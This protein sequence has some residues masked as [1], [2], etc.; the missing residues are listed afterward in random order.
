MLHILHLCLMHA[1]LMC[2]ISHFTYNFTDCKYFLDVCVL[3]YGKY[4]AKWYAILYQICCTAVA[5]IAWHCFSTSS[6]IG[7]PYADVLLAWHCFSSG[8]RMQMSLE[9]AHPTWEP[10]PPQF[11]P[12]T[13][14][15]PYTR[16]FS[17]CTVSLFTR[18]DDMLL[19][20]VLQH[21]RPHRRFPARSSKYTA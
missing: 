16:C 18:L 2:C 10:K 6:G 4:P 1:V 17:N 20:I 9:R 8:S 13:N 7:S 14:A 11:P 3:S 12:Q 15:Q 19:L 21:R 5:S